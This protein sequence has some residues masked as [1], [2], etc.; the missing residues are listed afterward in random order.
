MLSFCRY[1]LL[2]HIQILHLIDLRRVRRDGT[3]HIAAKGKHLCLLADSALSRTWP[4]TLWCV[5]CYS[6]GLVYTNGTVRARMGTSSD[7]LK[8]ASLWLTIWISGPLLGQTLSIAFQ[9]SYLF[10]TSHEFV[11]RP[12]MSSFESLFTLTCSLYFFLKIYHPTWH[13]TLTFFASS[14]FFVIFQRFSLL[15]I[16]LF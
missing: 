6:L 9:P 1:F 10:L 8:L 13:R 12:E 3:F 5:S 14:P 15:I 16:C 2:N 7:M 11:W 4:A